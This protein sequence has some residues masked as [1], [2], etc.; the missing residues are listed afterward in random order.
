MND[1]V[2]I[3][4][5]TTFYGHSPVLPCT[6]WVDLYLADPSTQVHRHRLTENTK[7]SK[8]VRNSY[9]KSKFTNMEQ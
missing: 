2:P 5:V 6:P 4:A 3:Y 7:Y 9:R 1:H 8:D